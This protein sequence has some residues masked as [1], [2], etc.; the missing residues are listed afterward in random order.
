[1]EHAN[2]LQQTEAL[3]DT[4]KEH[5]N[6]CYAEGEVWTQDSPNDIAEFDEIIKSDHCKDCPFYLNGLNQDDPIAKN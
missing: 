3:V 5:C 6:E 2:L 1:M 4:V